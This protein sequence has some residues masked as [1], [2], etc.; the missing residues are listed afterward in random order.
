MGAGRGGD[1]D[2]DLHHHGDVHVGAQRH[3]ERDDVRP[4]AGERPRTGV[5]VVAELL[6][7]RL[8]PLPG[9]HRDGPLP[10]E[11]IAHR[12]RGDSGVLRDLGKGDHSALH[13]GTSST[14]ARK[15]A[16]TGSFGQMWR[17]ASTS[18]GPPV[19]C[20]DDA[21]LDLPTQGVHR[22]VEALRLDVPAAHRTTPVSYTH[23]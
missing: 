20:P 16:C 23:L 10:A 13:Q 8:D 6:D 11:D 3:H 15:P 19:T 18:P 2:G 22:A 12:A 21:S 1:R 7:A 5:G 9:G 4:A 17:S 14:P